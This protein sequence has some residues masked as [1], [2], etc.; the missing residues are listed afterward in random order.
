MRPDLHPSTHRIE[1]IIEPMDKWVA[2][3]NK[4]GTKLEQLLMNE[5]TQ[6]QSSYWETNDKLIS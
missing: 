4:E 6:N 5:A 3:Y 2:L 1:N